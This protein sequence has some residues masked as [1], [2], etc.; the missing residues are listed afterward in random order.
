[1]SFLRQN[2]ININDRYIL[3]VGCGAGNISAFLATQAA[4]VHGFDAS[5]N[6]INYAQHTYGPMHHNL[7]FQQSFV[8][9]FKVYNTYDLATAFFCFQWFENQQQALINIADCLK[10]DGELLATISTQEDPTPHR[11]TIG[12]RLIEE[13]FPES[14]QQS[15]S[16]K[17]GQCRPSREQVRIMLETAGFEII[18]CDVQSVRVI[19]ANRK[20]VED[21]NRPVIMSRPFIQE[22]SNELREAFFNRYIDEIIPGYEKTENN[23]FIQD[24]ALTIIHAR[25]K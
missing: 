4:H 17:L 15:T 19:L 21:F 23:E 24:V 2:N 7:S 11:M 9:D 16:E 22:A 6:M 18:T 13:F 12:L 3:D 1:M 14:Q 20:E 25:K 8:E 5:N 10:K